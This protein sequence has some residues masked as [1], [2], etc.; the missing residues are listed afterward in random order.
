MDQALKK[1]N[2]DVVEPDHNNTSHKV[3]RDLVWL[4]Q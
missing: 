1:D 3:E 2:L 4:Q